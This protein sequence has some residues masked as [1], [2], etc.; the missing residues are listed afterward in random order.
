[1]A[2]IGKRLI[3][4]P[5]GV[6]V[7]IAN[8]VVKVKGPKGTLVQDYK[9][10][11]TIEVEGDKIKT[12]CLAKDPK[13]LALQGLYNSLITN[14][15]E[16]V[17]NGFEKRLEMVGVG[18]RVA[19]QGKGLQIAIGYSHPVM[20]EAPEAIELTTEG[21]NKIIVKGIDKQVVG[22]VAAKIRRIRKVEPYKG[23]GIKYVGERV[24]RKAGKAAKA[25]GGAA[26]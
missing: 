15:I 16:G 14:M 8:G 19:K 18:Y 13:I 1:M 6:Q 17:T 4:I 23:K 24:R 2:R 25:A 7:E 11:I 26:A 21:T 5:K 22:E 20:V 9:Q 12:L 10:A 3:Q